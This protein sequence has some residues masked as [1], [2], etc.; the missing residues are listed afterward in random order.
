[1]AAECVVDPIAARA[2]SPVVLIVED[3]I[4][5]RMLLCETLR[6]AG[7][8]VIEAANAEEAVVVLHASLDP[9]I[10]ITDVKMPGAIDGFELAAYVRDRKSVV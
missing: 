1:M 9:D 6:L 4:L 7:Y 10:L 8:V 2:A 5:I 3:E